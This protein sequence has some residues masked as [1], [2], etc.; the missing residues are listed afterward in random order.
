MTKPL[1]NLQVELLKSFNFE[2]DEDQL[3]E[4]KQMLV[5]YFAKKVTDGVDELFED[6]GWDD[7]KLEEWSEEHMRTPY[8]PPS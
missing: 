5:D 2:I 7:G 6:K 4:I 3:R 1:T 8:N